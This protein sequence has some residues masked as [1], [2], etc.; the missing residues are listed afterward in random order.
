MILIDVISDTVCPWCF[1]GKRRLEQAMRERPNYSFKVEWRPF[2]LNPEMPKQGMP[3]QQFLALKFGGDDRA[4]KIY[5][6]VETTA[7]EEGLDFRFSR[8]GN[9]PNTLASHR[10]IRWAGSAGVQDQVVEKLFQSY[11]FDGADIGDHQVLAELAET[12]GMDRELVGRLLEEGAD[13]KLVS[14]EELVARR[15]GIAGVPCF[16]VDGKYAVS[17]AQDSTV[18]HNVFDLSLQDQRQAGENKQTAQAAE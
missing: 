6:T 13:E 4:K 5:K 8:I 11:F 9:Q 14:E 16:I 18:L 17:G 2:Q 7:Q 10:L 3:R 12:V 1:I 15:M